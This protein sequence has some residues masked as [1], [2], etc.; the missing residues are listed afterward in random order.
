MPNRSK[1]VITPQ[2][3]A[4]RLTAQEVAKE[5]LK[6]RNGMPLKEQQAF[7][8][9]L[10]QEQRRF[11]VWQN[12]QDEKADAAAYQNTNTQLSRIAT[13]AYANEF[14]KRNTIWSETDEDGT[15]RT[16]R[17]DLHPEKVDQYKY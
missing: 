11:E 14:R 5:L 15:V 1:P 3:T 16:F 17:G 6:V 4:H 12:D 2:R 10:K 7:D 13:D 8:R 9:R